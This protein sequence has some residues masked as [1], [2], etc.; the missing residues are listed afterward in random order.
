MFLFSTIKLRH[1]TARTTLGNALLTAAFSDRRRHGNWLPD[2]SI[3]KAE[4]RRQLC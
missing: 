2:V 1:R 4:V 3:Q